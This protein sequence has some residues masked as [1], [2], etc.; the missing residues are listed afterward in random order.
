MSQRVIQARGHQGGCQLRGLVSSSHVLMNDS[1]QKFPS[2]SLTGKRN[3][4]DGVKLSIATL[5]TSP[6]HWS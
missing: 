5:K 6:R 1:F 2:A 3:G 4:N